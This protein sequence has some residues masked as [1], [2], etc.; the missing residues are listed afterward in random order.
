[1]L[2]ILHMIVVEYILVLFLAYHKKIL[3]SEDIFKD[4]DVKDDSG[5]TPLMWVCYRIDPSQYKCRPLVKAKGPVLNFFFR[6]VPPQ[7]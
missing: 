6:N 5:A 7:H 3:L 4:V 2:Q 1:M